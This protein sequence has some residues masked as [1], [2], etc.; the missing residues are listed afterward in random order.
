M[1]NQ[2]KQNISLE[3][4]IADAMVEAHPSVVNVVAMEV[5]PLHCPTICPNTTSA[6]PSELE[7][8]EMAPEVEQWHG[9]IAHPSTARLTQA[10][11][12]AIA[13]NSKLDG[14]HFAAYR[15]GLENT[16]ALSALYDNLHASGRVDEAILRNELTMPQEIGWQAT[17]EADNAAKSR[18]RSSN[19]DL[20]AIAL[21]TN[22]Q[23][24]LLDQVREAFKVT[25]ELHKQ[26]DDVAKHGLVQE[27][28]KS[29]GQPAPQDV[30]PNNA[31][32]KTPA[33]NGIDIAQLRQIPDT[34]LSGVEF[35]PIED[36]EQR[37]THQLP[38]HNLND[39]VFGDNSV[40]TH[41]QLDSPVCE[42]P[43]IA[44]PP[45]NF[46]SHVWPLLRNQSNK[47]S[48]NAGD[49]AYRVTS[50]IVRGSPGG[51][52]TMGEPTSAIVGASQPKQYPMIPVDPP[53]PQ[54]YNVFADNNVTFT[55]PRPISALSVERL[56]SYINGTVT[57]AKAF[58]NAIG[59]ILNPANN[60]LVRNLASALTY[61][62]VRHDMSALYVKLL[63]PALL[64][65]Q[66]S[67]DANMTAAAV[68]FPAG[69]AP[70]FINL[71]TA[72]LSPDTIA[73]PIARGD[74]MLLDTEDYAETDLLMWYWISKPGAR[75]A[76]GRD[77][78][79]PPAAV[80]KFPA[81]PV[82]ILKHGA[83]PA[84]PAA[85]VPTAETVWSFAYKLATQR[86]ELNDFVR[87]VY[88][89]AEFVFGAWLQTDE[90]HPTV[91]QSNHYAAMDSYFQ[92]AGQ[93]LYKPS[94]YNIIHRWLKLR[95]TNAIPVY[96]EA[97][98]FNAL[99]VQ[100][101]QR[102]LA[103]YAAM[104]SGMCS[105]VLNSMNLGGNQLNQWVRGLL[106]PPLLAS[107]GNA[108]LFTTGEGL[109]QC[110]ALIFSK[111]RET[112][113]RCTGLS[114]PTGTKL[115][116]SWNGRPGE[117]NDVFGHELGYAQ[118]SAHQ[119]P[120]YGSVIGIDDWVK[121]RPVEWGM[122][123]LAPTVSFKHDILRVGD[124]TRRGFYTCRGDK[125]FVQRAASGAPYV[126]VPY[127]ALAMNTATQI[128]ETQAGMAIR[129]SHMPWDPEGEPQPEMPI[130]DNFDP[131]YDGALKMMHACTVTTFDWTGSIVIAPVILENALGGAAALDRLYRIDGVVVENAGYSKGE[132]A[133]SAQPMLSLPAM[134][135]SVLK[136]VPP[137]MAQGERD[138]L[139]SSSGELPTVPPIASGA[140]P[141]NDWAQG[142]IAGGQALN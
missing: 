82:T 58:E 78:Y 98:T 141:Q 63:V 35:T 97:M 106:V 48:Y 72:D 42:L 79:N 110:E 119:T 4:A 26:L 124:G 45:P 132:P 113:Y 30:V 138:I 19:A 51:G 33:A 65:Q 71:S 32:V 68:A 122:A 118:L 121:I 108:G 61:G 52:L 92:A 102:V 40:H 81:I 67:D 133:L 13:L 137:V 60:H 49:H 75:L 83:A 18:S 95:P 129:Y 127:A 5:P 103:L 111:T 86:D 139:P 80:L 34:G 74:I 96:P 135:H 55:S 20:A 23:G 62:L 84:A 17:L 15:E 73:R 91:N 93:T 56:A 140:P 117:H 25:P 21:S 14:P 134:F 105:T 112:I 116:H 27:T 38:T 44:L 66:I 87:A 43:T 24:N 57:S 10:E 94:D 41:G 12:V 37:D 76:T 9:E 64:I 115:G 131:T 29:Y 128:L 123:S 85:A 2:P 6:L 107:L 39:Q 104:V 16:P 11:L 77:D 1:S 50:Y 3:S 47:V 7:S 99:S 114:V 53:L 8:V 101:K 22:A 88:Q 136:A 69:D 54:I 90:I 70:T 59:P 46:I 28:L 120:R 126:I 31:V 36:D 125:T 100:S 142:D 89:A 130:N 109:A